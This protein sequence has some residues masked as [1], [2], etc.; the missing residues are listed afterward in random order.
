MPAPPPV[1]RRAR[2]WRRHPLLTGALIVVALIGIGHAKGRYDDWRDHAP[3]RTVGRAIAATHEQVAVI[4]PA[5]AES[6][7]G[8]GG[9][10]ERIALDRIESGNAYLK[11][12][13]FSLGGLF[14]D[15][16]TDSQA[17]CYYFAVQRGTTF[18]PDRVSAI[19]RYC[20]IGSGREAYAGGLR[21][22][23]RP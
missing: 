17:R 4:S 14:P 18:V 10:P 2:F 21:S 12:I 6:W 13:F 1:V 20:Y 3:L 5:M 9:P 16:P 7:G 23:D 19:T 11:P 8:G 22:V 15:E